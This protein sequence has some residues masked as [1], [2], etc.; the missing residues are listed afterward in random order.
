MQVY[1]VIDEHWQQY[2]L[3]VESLR[4][5]TLLLYI[6]KNIIIRSTLGT[7]DIFKSSK[8]WYIIVCLLSIQPW[9]GHQERIWRYG[10]WRAFFN[11]CCVEWAMVFICNRS[12]KHTTSSSCSCSSSVLIDWARGR[13]RGWPLVWVRWGRRRRRRRRGWWWHV[14]SFFGI[15]LCGAKQ[16]P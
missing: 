13:T 8:G 15:A 7:A 2:S 9:R 14:C 6:I 12:S 5:K 4:Y 10:P 3:F 11:G 16:S 1:Q